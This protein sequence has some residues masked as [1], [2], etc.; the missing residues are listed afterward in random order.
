MAMNATVNKLLK[1]NSKKVA[2]RQVE[3]E[4]DEESEKQE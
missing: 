3:S 4:I 2:S 1:T